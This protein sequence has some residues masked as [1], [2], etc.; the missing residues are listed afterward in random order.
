MSG[1]LARVNHQDEEDGKKLF[2]TVCAPRLAGKTTLAGTLPGKTLLLQ[3]AVRESG[4][5]SAKKLANRL[6][7]DL[8]IQTL[9]SLEEW[10]K[11]LAELAQ[12]ETYDN[13][14]VDGVSALNEVVYADPKTV[15]AMNSDPRKGYK[16]IGDEMDALLMT[17]K[18]LTYPSRCKKPKNVFMTVALKI[19]SDEGV[20]DVKLEVKGKMSVSS[21]TK[22]GEAVLTVVAPVKTETGTT[23]HKLLTQTDGFWP[24]RVDGLLDD[25]NPGI[26]EPAD[27]GA[28]LKLIDGETAA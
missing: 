11:K 8:T 24:G 1:V 18:G 5:R 10:T 26:I 7:N 15:R 19:E 3:V 20:T 23:K 28:L 21:I 13:I 27:L 25:E 16:L 12:D 22:L 2:A 9:H 4:S 6:G 17:I 14:Y